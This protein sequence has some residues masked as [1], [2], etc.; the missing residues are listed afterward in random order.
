MRGVKRERGQRVVERNKGCLRVV[1]RV[2]ERG[3]GCLRV[4]EGL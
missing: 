1:K 2:V 3:K 4:V